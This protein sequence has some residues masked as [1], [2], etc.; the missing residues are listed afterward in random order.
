ML[1]SHGRA[2][3]TDIINHTTPT[4]VEVTGTPSGIVVYP[5]AGGPRRRRRRGLSREVDHDLNPAGTLS[6][7]DLHPE[8]KWVR[9]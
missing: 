4:H 9:K 1:K 5:K 7:T 8:L 2:N 3:D 6:E